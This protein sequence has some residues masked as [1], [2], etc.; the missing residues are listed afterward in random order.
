MAIEKAEQIANQLVNQ[1]I[2]EEERKNKQE[3]E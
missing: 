3:R 1:Q 2:D